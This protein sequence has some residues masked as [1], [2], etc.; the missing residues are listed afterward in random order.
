ML[1]SLSLLACVLPYLT[2]TPCLAQGGVQL[3]LDGAPG[4]HGALVELSVTA[5]DTKPT[6]P[7]SVQV[8]LSLYIAARTPSSD[9]L[10]L[11]SARL[12][13]AGITTVLPTTDKRLASLFVLDA[14]RVRSRVG[15]GLELTITTTDGPPT[16]VRLERP[17]RL[18]S[19]S[20]LRIAALGRSAVDGR[21]GTGVLTLELGAK[22]NAPSVSNAL[23]KEAGALGWLS[24]RPELNS[25]RPL[26][27]GVGLQ[28]VGCS[29]RISSADPWWLDVGL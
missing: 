28:V 17:T 29:L 7:R 14:T 26:R 24:D 15:D 10:A 12:R 22:A 1:R 11:L 27:I 13:A 21:T 5:F 4:P 25:W 6:E 3:S 8:D 9:V 23:H 16:W 18:E 20:T 2:T 19:A